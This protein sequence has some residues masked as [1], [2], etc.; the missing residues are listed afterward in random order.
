MVVTNKRYVGLDVHKHYVMVG[1][2]DG[3]QQVVLPPRK[4]ALVE[5][6]G[7]AK[8]YLRSSDQVVLE[9]TTNAWYVHDL[10]EPIV[11][12]GVVPLSTLLRLAG[13]RI[14]PL[15]APIL[16]R[17]AHYPSQAQ[18]GDPPAAFYDYLRWLWVADGARGFDAFGEPVYTTKEAWISF[19][20]ARRMRRYR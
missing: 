9:A 16:F 18:T 11:G 13:K 8:K 10:L 2:V 3:N 12:R 14:L 1:A 15:P 20:S 7:W 6:E 19:V 4:V 17:M 5:L